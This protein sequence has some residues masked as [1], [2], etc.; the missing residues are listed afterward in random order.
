MTVL[1]KPTRTFLRTF[2]LS[3]VIVA[4]ILFG[5]LG[6][7]RAYENTRRIAFGDYRPAIEWTED[8]LRI[9]DF[10]DSQ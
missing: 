2:W 3:C 1:K 8:G 7:I 10:F 9:L 6:I 4:C 5:G